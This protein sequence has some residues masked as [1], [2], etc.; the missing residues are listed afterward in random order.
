MCITHSMNK[1]VIT[2]LLGVQNPVLNK[3]RDGSQHEGHKQVHV[4]EVPGAVKLP[5]DRR[6]KEGLRHYMRLKF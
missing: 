5:V 2:F 4:D 1:A 6:S 3:H